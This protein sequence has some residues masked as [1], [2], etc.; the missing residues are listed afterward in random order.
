MQTETLK[1]RKLPKFRVL[2]FD[3]GFRVLVFDLGFRVLVFDLGFRVL[4]FDLGFR[5]WDSG[6]VWGSGFRV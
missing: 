5:V 4:V 1:D 6:R 3:L 2:V